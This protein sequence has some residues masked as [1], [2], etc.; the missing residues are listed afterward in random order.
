M[1]RCFS[2]S[3][4]KAFMIWRLGAGQASKYS[5]GQRSRMGDLRGEGKVSDLQIKGRW[6]YYYV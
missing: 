3:S 1:E 6:E 4:M 2:M 5:F